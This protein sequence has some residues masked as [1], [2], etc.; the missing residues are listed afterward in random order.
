MS[1]VP[2]ADRSRPCQT[3]MSWHWSLSTFPVR[4]AS[5]QRTSRPRRHTK[6]SARGWS[7]SSIPS[8][9]GRNRRRVRS[10]AC[11]R[12]AGKR[13]GSGFPL[14]A[15]NSGELS[16][17]GWAGSFQHWCDAGIRDVSKVQGPDEGGEGTHLPQTA[18]VDMSAMHQSEDA[19]TKGI[20][21]VGLM[22]A[23]IFRQ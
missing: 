22:F 18:K 2:A 21:K 3:E 4:A 20:A 23:A 10:C 15:K 14:A 9:R 12:W 5:T 8:G 19:K 13:S 11:V 7:S 1:R 17:G 6:L 16:A